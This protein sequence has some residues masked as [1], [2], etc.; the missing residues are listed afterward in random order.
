MY[1]IMLIEDDTALS[2]LI[3]EHLEKYGYIAYGQEDFNN[4]EEQF[5][6]LK[7]DLV[8]LDINLPYYD[9]FYFC[10]SI[11]KKSRVPIIITSARSG[12]MD[13][14]MAIELGADNYITKP[15]KFE[16][17]LAKIKAALRR[18]YGEYAV[19]EQKDLRVK[20]LSINENSLKM[21]Y[22]GNTIELSKNEYI[23]IRKFIENKDRIISR[24]ELF[25]ELWDDSCFVDDN[26]LTVNITRIKNKF[27]ELGVRDIIKTK[28]KVG[29]I[30]DYAVL[31]GEGND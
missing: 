28:R 4:I 8:L 25:E 29:Y 16:I 26:T 24:E 10:R 14:V 11:R 31:E 18:T 1:K 7:P 17:L 5:E 19:K 23:L 21:D 20:G 13:Q 6:I 12:E 15:L 30:F 3:K 2:C 9:G 27:L 22:M